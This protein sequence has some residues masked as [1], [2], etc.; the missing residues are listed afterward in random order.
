MVVT[1]TGTRSSLTTQ[2][3]WLMTAR[4]IGM[5][6]SIALP[7]VLVR[8]FTASQFGTY[9]Q[10]FQ[11]ISTAVILLPFSFGMTLFY[12]LP[13][14]PEKASVVVFNNLLY[15]TVVGAAVMILLTVAPGALRIVSSGEALTPVAGL[16]GMVIW[17]WLFSSLL[18]QI[19]TARGDVFWSTV[20]IIVAQ[21]SRAGM[22]LAAAVVYRTVEMVL[23]ACLVQGLLQSG[24]L[25]WYLG[26]Q[27]PGYW[28]RIDWQ[29]AGEQVRYTLP[30]GII[31]L[32]YVVQID[33]H[34]YLVANRF[35][36]ADF[37]I[38]AVGT[39]Q[40]PF[41]GI[42]RDS[43]NTVMIPRASKLQQEGN[44]AEMLRILMKSWH[45]LAAVIVPVC[46]ALFVLRNDFISTLYRSQYLPASPIFALNL[47]LVVLSMFGST[48]AIIRAHV[49]LQGWMI[50]VRLA[51]LVFQGVVSLI[52]IP[53]FGMIGALIGMVAALVVERVVSLRVIFQI[54]DFRR[55]D[56]PL[57]LGLAGFAAS[58]VAAAAA[59]MAALVGL[60]GHPALVRLTAGCGVFGAVYVACVIGFKVLDSEEKEMVN[61]AS[62]RL[63]K[64]RLL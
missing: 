49:H 61:R 46:A 28:R 59:T 8:V 26:R 34:N 64:V 14:Q 57:L 13:R 58:S 33:L 23:Y 24:L 4:T 52:A 54:L 16:I 1:E 43:V 9:K 37:A 44:K 5:V 55:A 47:L 17:T 48:D 62:L 7:V 53:M 11:L 30:L 12:F 40:I 27:Y 3:F 31:G 29:M 51:S 19:A 50:R 63:L 6:I 21:C 10:V 2:A 45:K 22:M 39:S 42:L 32:M 56:M 20:F 36:P 18:E 35:S 15:L 38:Y 25:L 60:S 41:L